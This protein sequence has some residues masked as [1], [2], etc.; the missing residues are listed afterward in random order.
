MKALLKW[1]IRKVFFFSLLF[2]FFGALIFFFSETLLPPLSGFL[3]ASEDP[4]E[5]EAIVVLLGA[6]QPDRILKAHELYSEG[7]APMILFGTGFSDQKLESLKPEGFVWPASSM[8][9]IV[10]LESLGVPRDSIELVNTASDYDTASELTSIG[11]YARANNIES[12]TLV[13]SKSHTRRIK[14]IWSRV[15][16]D[17]ASFVVGAEAPGFDRWWEQGNLIRGVGYEYA[18]LTKELYRQ[19]SALLS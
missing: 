13:S 18:A 4:A 10:A 19:I 1:C 8:R 5:T 3:D 6:S 16:P 2:G 15:N 12:L 14:I 7:L 9:Y 11:T 17:I